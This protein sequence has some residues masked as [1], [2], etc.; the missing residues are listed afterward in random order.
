MCVSNCY[1]FKGNNYSVC[2]SCKPG[3]F[4]TSKGF[5]VSHIPNCEDYEDTQIYSA[6]SCLKCED[7]YFRAEVN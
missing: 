7:A 1:T 5:C 4:M 6:V 2:D 3:Y